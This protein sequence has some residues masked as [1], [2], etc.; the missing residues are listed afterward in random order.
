M[1]HSGALWMIPIPKLESRFFTFSVFMHVMFEHLL[2]ILSLRVFKLHVDSCFQD[3]VD[4]EAQ[5][6]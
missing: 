4:K 3:L 2:C 6:K 1:L 5:R